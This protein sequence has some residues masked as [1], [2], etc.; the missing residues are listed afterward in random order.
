MCMDATTPLPT[1]S[2]P[3]VA[4]G[5][6]DVTNWVDALHRQQSIRDEREDREA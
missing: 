2:V 5:E 6:A 1:A 4:T 3:R